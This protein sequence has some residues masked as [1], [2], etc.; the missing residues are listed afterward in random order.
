MFRVSLAAAA[1]FAVASASAVP[2][3]PAAPHSRSGP[4]VAVEDTLHTEI[5]EILV[6]APR[7]TL[8]D[9]LDLVARGEARRD[10]MI[11]DQVYTMTVRVVRNVADAK[12][13]PEKVSE[14]VA[15]VYQRKPDQVRVVT[16]RRWRLKPRK[17]GDD[18]VSVDFGSDTSE[19]IVNFAFRPEGR[20]AYRYR[21]VGRDLLGDRLIYR[22]AFEPRS[23]LDA[24]SPSGVVWVDT[25]EFVIVRQEVR[26]ER[27]PAPLLLRGVDRMVIERERVNGLWVL[28]RA[29]LRLRFTLPLPEVGRSMDASIQFTDYAINRGIADAIFAAPAAR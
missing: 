20:R 23:A 3:A 5:P 21:I 10:S 18:P 17:N 12:R 22:I 15:R 4:T 27:S 28:R 19:E 13:A 2:A 8:E 29:L 7:M 24:A 1:L 14:T 6:S 25:N 26:F 16:L 9:I 11:H